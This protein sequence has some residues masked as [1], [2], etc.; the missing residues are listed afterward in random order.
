MQTATAEWIKNP[1]SKQAIAELK[2]SL[3]PVTQLFASREEAH[4]DMMANVVR[5]ALQEAL[6]AGCYPSPEQFAAS[7]R[8]IWL[9][10]YSKYAPSI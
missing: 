3:P 8:V 5:P 10:A 9:E 2:A 7:M 1:S 4:A 6:E